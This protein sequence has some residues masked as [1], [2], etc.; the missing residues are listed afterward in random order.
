MDH[1]RQVFSEE[2][3]TLWRNWNSHCP[4]SDRLQYLIGRWYSEFETTFD[5]T[6]SL[7]QGCV[8]YG[9]SNWKKT[10]DGAMFTVT[11]RPVVKG[12]M[13]TI[14]RLVYDTWRFY[15]PKKEF[16]FLRRRRGELVG[17]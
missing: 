15:L 11:R 8:K 4:P 3:E 13:G 14:G 9:S 10:E 17:L 1:Y 2:L 12:S 6:H 7:T 16:L 5:G